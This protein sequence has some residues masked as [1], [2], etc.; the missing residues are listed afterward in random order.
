MTV[1]R[2]QTIAWF[3]DRKGELTYSM[4][5]SRNGSDGTADCSGSIT[6]AVRDAGGVPYDYLYS[7][8]TLAGY[9]EKN[10]YKRISVNQDWDAEA[11]DIILMSW[12]NDMSTSGGAGGHVGVMKDQTRFISVDYWTGGT[13]GTAV[14]EHV[15]NNYY[16]VQRPNYIEV[17]RPSGEGSANNN[18]IENMEGINMECIL[19]KGNAQYYY[20]GTEIKGLANPDESKAIGDVYKAIHGK[21]ITVVKVTDSELNSLLAVSKRKAI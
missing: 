15:W 4:Y 1:S 6:Q 14:S 3:D 9:F 12:G 16:A 21:N 7:T 8:V 2:Q 19:E 10:G 17:W 5:G 20:N 18:K 11:G 13:I